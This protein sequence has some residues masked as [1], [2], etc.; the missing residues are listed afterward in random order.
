VFQSINLIMKININGTQKEFTEVIKL[1]DL[2]NKYCKQPRCIVT[3][4]NGDIILSKDWENTILKENDSI[5]LVTPVG[6]G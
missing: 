4:V 1:S 3:A 2:V 6:G 5:D